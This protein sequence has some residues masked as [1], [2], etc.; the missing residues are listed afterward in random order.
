MSGNGYGVVA[1]GVTR[2]FGTVDALRGLDL[3]VPY[4]Q[5]FL[6]ALA[7]PILGAGA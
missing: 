1:R 7:Y 6:M 2:R 3:E 4:G 5:V